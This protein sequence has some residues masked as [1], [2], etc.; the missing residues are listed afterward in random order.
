VG[1]GATDGGKDMTKDELDLAIIEFAVGEISE[2]WF[3]VF[4]L[5]LLALGDDET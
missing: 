3:G 2:G 1:G 4:V 5:L